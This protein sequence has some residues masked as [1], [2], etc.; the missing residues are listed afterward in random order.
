LGLAAVRVEHQAFYRRLFMMK[1]LCE[2]RMFPNLTKLFSL[3]GINYMP[4]RDQIIRRYPFMN[5]SM[6]EMTALFG[7]ERVDVDMSGFKQPVPAIEQ[8]MVHH[9]PA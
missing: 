7:R 6:A 2:P 3:M 9:E 5:S 1:P 4:V 8:A